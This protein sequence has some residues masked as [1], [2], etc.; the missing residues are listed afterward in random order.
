M[1]K[2]DCSRN[3]L[4]QLKYIAESQKQNKPLLIK[5]AITKNNNSKDKGKEAENKV[6]LLTF[7]SF[8]RGNEIY[9]KKWINHVTR[10]FYFLFSW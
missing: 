4:I 7:L 1:F 3:N 5:I 2:I 10:S 8:P 6:S 9:F